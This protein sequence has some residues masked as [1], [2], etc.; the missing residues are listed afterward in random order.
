MARIHR[1]DD[2]EQYRCNFWDSYDSQTDD[3]HI[4]L[5][6][7]TARDGDRDCNNLLAPG[8]LNN[9]DASVLIER[10]YARAD[11][12]IPIEILARTVVMLTMGSQWIREIPMD[13]LFHHNHILDTRG[14]KVDL[15]FP[16]RQYV[17]VRV[18]PSRIKNTGSAGRIWIHMV[19]VPYREQ[20]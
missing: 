4:R 10:W 8:T 11:H 6:N 18:A 5:F 12:T 16:T 19:V 9:G 20:R 7:Q 17:E 1:Y 14:E 3:N 2:P 13:H 15:V